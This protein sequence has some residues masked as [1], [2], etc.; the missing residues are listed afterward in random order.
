M[1]RPW[2]NNDVEFPVFLLESRI[3]DTLVAL[4]DKGPVV[5]WMPHP[6]EEE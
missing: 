2:D 6:H 3:W 1:K 4:R 5:Q